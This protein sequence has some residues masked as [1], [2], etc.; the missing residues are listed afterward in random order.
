MKTVYYFVGI[1]LTGKIYPV[2]VD[3]LNP[4]SAAPIAE[5]TDAFEAQ[6]VSVP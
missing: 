2:G 5:F 3:P 6:R 4:G 1:L